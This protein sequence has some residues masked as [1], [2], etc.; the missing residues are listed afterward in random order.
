V[1]FLLEKARLWVNEAHPKTRIVIMTE[2][3]VREWAKREN[4]E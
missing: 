4:I 1:G 2:D 3:E